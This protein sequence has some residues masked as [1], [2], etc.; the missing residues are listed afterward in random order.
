MA[1]GERHPGIAGAL[2]E[3]RK[4]V[5]GEERAPKSLVEAAVG[6]LK[7]V[8]YVRAQIREGHSRIL[9]DLAPFWALRAMVEG[10]GPKVHFVEREVME[11][12]VEEGVVPPNVLV[13]LGSSGV[14]VAEL[15]R[16]ARQRESSKA[17]EMR[18]ARAEEAFESEVLEVPRNCT[19]LHERGEEH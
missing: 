13:H 10:L 9:E 6:G 11:E 4:M 8:A 3:L 19:S 12:V 18:E 2:V 15:Q 1:E 14:E 5:M 7:K 16:R 17:P